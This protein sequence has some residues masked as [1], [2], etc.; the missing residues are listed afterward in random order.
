MH[1]IAIITVFNSNIVFSYEIVSY[2][3]TSK[4]A[5][6]YIQMIENWGHCDFFINND[7]VI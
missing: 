4:I 2:D 6:G 5:L 7:S 1:V 3:L